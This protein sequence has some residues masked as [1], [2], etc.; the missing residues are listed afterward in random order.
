MKTKT[1][2][3]T[4]IRV[5]WILLFIAVLAFAWLQRETHDM[6][7]AATLLVMGISLPAG[8]MLIALTGTAQSSFAER[9]GIPYDAFGDFVPYW[10]VAALTVYMQWFW[11]VPKLLKFWAA[12]R[13]RMPGA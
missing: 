5:A 2:L 4:A 13:R 7:V 8:P 11:L 9:F 3:L 6:P 1:V 10:L 12:R